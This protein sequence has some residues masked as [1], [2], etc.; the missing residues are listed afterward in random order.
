MP[1]LKILFISESENSFFPKLSHKLERNLLRFQPTIYVE[2][3]FKEIYEIKKHKDIIHK[4]DLIVLNIGKG[5]CSDYYQKFQ[6]ELE[7]IIHEFPQ[8]FILLIDEKC[9][10]ERCHPCIEEIRHIVKYSDIRELESM[11]SHLIRDIIVHDEYFLSN[12]LFKDTSRAEHL[13]REK[14]K[15]IKELEISSQN[16]Q[17]K[18]EQAIKEKEFLEKEATKLKEKIAF[19][20]EEKQKETDNIEKIITFLAAMPKEISNEQKYLEKRRQRFTLLGGLSFSLG[21]ISIFILIINFSL[22]KLPAINGASSYLAYIFPVVFPMVI[23]FLFYRQSN[24]KSKEIEKIN[25]KSILVQQ[26]EN[27]LNSYNVLLSGDELKEKTISSIDRV[28]NKIFDNNGKE[29]K[30]EKVEESKLTIS[31]VQKLFKMGNDITKS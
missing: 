14:E 16:T 25:E 28:I 24:M 26:V 31:D 2:F 22:T 12:D 1:K 17:I 19:L 20:E 30:S 9:K 7:Y 5:S 23:S 10:D 15:K 4:Y 3:Q 21:I 18:G 8:K 13:L 29:E 6:Y 27:A 11:L